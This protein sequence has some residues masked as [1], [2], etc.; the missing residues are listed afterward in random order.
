MVNVS[1]SVRVDLLGGTI[2]LNPI[3]LILPHAYTLNLAT[4]LKARV[5]IEKNQNNQIIIESLD[6]STTY[7]YNLTDFTEENYRSEFFGPMNFVCQI[8]GFFKIHSGIKVRLQSGSPAGAGL[9]GSSSMGVTL[10]KA[11]CQ[12]TN[13]KLDKLEAIRTVNMIEARIL[14]SGPAG[15]QDYYPAMFGG[16]LALKPT[17]GEIK[18]EQLY[19]KEL[20]ESLEKHITLIYSGE[21][22]LSGIN[23]WEVYKAFFDKNDTVR[24]GMKEIADLSYEAYNAIKLK[25]YKI[26]PELIG[27]EGKV[28][29]KLFSGIVSPKMREVFD[30]IKKEVPELG[31]KV[32]GAGGGGCFL[33][34]HGPDRKELIKKAV[35]EQGM[36]ILD[37]VID[38]PQ[39]D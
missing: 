9:G 15:Y 23:N 24:K 4:S 31:M 39:E 5:E 29:E 28:R 35:N 33:L 6:Y 13:K 16:I 3:N 7:T 30:I 19:T 10:F 34:V 37:F 38:Q 25:D 2:D 12:L 20:K 27:K 18:L 1:G 21:T 22:R 8:I 14:D 32:C 36:K 11:M 26:I 17:P